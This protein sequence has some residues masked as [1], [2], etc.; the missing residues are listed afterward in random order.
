MDLLSKYNAVINLE[1]LAE[2]R[3]MRKGTDFETGNRRERVFSA[4]LS[5]RSDH[6]AIIDCV[7]GMHSDWFS[8]K[9]SE[10]H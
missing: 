5:F 6:P 9:N 4:K 2:V 7:S 8:F 3:Q 1:M 10:L